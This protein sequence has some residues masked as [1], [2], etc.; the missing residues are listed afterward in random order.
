MRVGFLRLD[1]RGGVL[2][3]E[4]R[5]VEKNEGGPPHTLRCWSIATR[6]RNLELRVR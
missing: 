5:R 3:H 1:I 2:G 4:S 6:P